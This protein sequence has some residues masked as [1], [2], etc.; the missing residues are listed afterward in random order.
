MMLAPLVV[1]FVIIVIIYYLVVRGLFF[2]LILL[3]A[4]SICIYIVLAS[5]A[6]MQAPAFIVGGVVFSWA[7]AL[8]LGLVVLVL[9]TSRSE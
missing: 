3:V 9:L 7:S 4:G 1:L 6:E 8:P 5:Q 2:K